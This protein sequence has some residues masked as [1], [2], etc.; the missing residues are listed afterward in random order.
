MMSLDCSNFFLVGGTVID[1]NN[2][3]ELLEIYTEP[4][5]ISIFNTVM[6]TAAMEKLMLVI[7]S[8]YAIR[9]FH[10]VQ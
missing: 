9:D 10:S 7:A 2:G 4:T 1:L 5:E 6:G 8:S 3:L